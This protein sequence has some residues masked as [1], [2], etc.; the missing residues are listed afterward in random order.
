MLK[1]N[2]SAYMDGEISDSELVDLL[3]KDEALQTAWG[4][5]HVVRCVIKQESECI[6]DAG[7]TAKMADLIDAEPSEHLLTSQ[8][9]PQETHNS[10]FMRKFKNL[11]T[12]LTQVAVAAGVCLVAVVGVQSFSGSSQDMPATPVLQTLPFNTSVQE[13]SYNTPAQDTPT[14]EELEK[15]SKRI[16]AMLQNYELQRRININAPSVNRVAN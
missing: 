4:D 2:I 14:K 11:L 5:Y 7:F 6:L 15:Q 13:V 10:P 3:C 1:E 16:G 9:T 8:P 12:P